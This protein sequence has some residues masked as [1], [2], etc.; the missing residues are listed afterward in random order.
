MFNLAVILRESAA[1]HPD[2][3]VT[4]FDGRP[5]TYGEL[6]A[7][8]DRC[9]HGLR[10]RGVEPGDAVGLQL[11]NIPHFLIAYFGA[12]K[13]GAVVVPMNVLL[14]APEV[15]YYL[16]DSGAKLLITYA[17]V[18]GDAAKGAAD[19]GVSQLFAVGGDAEGSAQPFE[20]LLADEPPARVFESREPTDT[21]VVIYTSGTTGR[22][23]GA[24][25]TH[26]QLY[27]NCDIPGR[28][29][30]MQPNDVCLTALPLF[31]VFGLSS[32][33]N[34]AVR[35][36]GTMSLVPRFDAETALTTIERDRCTVF[37]GVPTM[38]VAMLHAESVD[39]RDLSTLRIAISGG[40]AIPAEVM[41]AFEAKFGVTILEGY[42]LSETASTTTFNVSAEER[43]AYSVG[44]PIWGTETAIWDEDGNELPRGKD[45]VGELVTRGAHV[46][47]GYLGNRRGHRGGVQGRLVPHR[48]PRLPGR[49]RVLLHRRPQEGTDHPRRLQ[50]LPARDR[51]GA[52]RPPG[53]AGGRRHRR[54]GRAPRRGG[55]GGRRPEAGPLAQRRGG[56]RL[57][58]GA[59]GGVQVPSAG[60]VP[61]RAAEERHRQDPQAGALLTM[62]QLTGLDAAFLAM[63][64]P[65]VFGHVGSICLLDPSTAREPLTLD[66]MTELVQSR[67]HLVPPMRRRLAEVPLGLDQP[68]WIEDPDFDIEYHVREI[69]LP[70]PGSEDQL[71]EQAA[72]LHARPL[73]RARPLW[74][75]YLISGLAGGRLAVYTKIHHAAIDGVSGN[76]LMAALLDVSPDGRD[77]TPPPWECDDVPGPLGLLARS[78]V[79]LSAQP[80]RAARVGAELV[81]TA[82][83]LLAG[84]ARPALPLID[85]VLFR[86][87]TATLNRLPMRAPRTPFNAPITAHRRAG[88][89]DIS[90]DDVRAVKAAAGVTVNDV[91]MAMSAG[92]LRRWLIDHDA[93]PDGPLVAA[94]P[95]SIRTEEQKGTHGNRVSAMLAVLPTHLADPLERLTV[96]ADAT[97][98]AKQQ[99][100][101][102]PA[103]LLSDISEFSMP[104]LAGRAARLGARM[105]LIERV[106]PFNLFV[107]NVPGPKVPLYYGGA[108]MLAYYPMSAI[109]D[110]QGLNI[111]VISYLGRMF[112]GL[113]ACR[114]LVPDVDKLAGYLD[115]ELQLL[116]EA[117]G[118]AA[119]S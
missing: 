37:E 86:N 107:S 116:R 32:V 71:A 21:A 89:R 77:L 54:E 30:G 22:P 23:K 20:A 62:R 93:L 117:V 33:L 72:R 84:P 104:A 74:E 81:R 103:E 85:R 18:L 42:G 38:Y 60:R 79:S 67:L 11:P 119:A 94:I 83:A 102:L 9:A 1:V 13:A 82:P 34:V 58:E 36:G 91:V 28:L 95:V 52:L 101:A 97:R 69:A 66:R 110:G 88:F 90:L 3:A 15:A 92:A 48:R 68:Y 35:F 78:F 70:A 10:Q 39:Q 19:A 12:L 7:M 53:R 57:H 65:T 45:H 49:G 96:S 41:D 43:K 25:L 76:D 8:S 56:G 51:R 80:L 106:N 55:Q 5:M 4:L 75:I 112:F 59:G 26:F 87:R 27:M 50:R 61:A 47:K 46:M 114:E 98:A 111:T 64:T 73:D 16:E 63:E 17:A 109:A 29:F 14:K 115:D 108:K 6:D 40:A 118:A 24:E 44:K 31:H 99:H 105:R 2:K 113:L 100:G